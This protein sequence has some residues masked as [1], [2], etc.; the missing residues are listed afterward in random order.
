MGPRLCLEQ[1]WRREIPRTSGLV[2]DT[3][4]TSNYP[5][6]TLYV[7]SKHLLSS[8]AQML[9]SNLPPHSCLVMP[10]RVPSFFPISRVQGNV[11][12]WDTLGM[13]EI[14]NEGIEK[15]ARAVP[16]EP[17]GKARVFGKDKQ[18]DRTLSLLICTS[19][20]HR[21]VFS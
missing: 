19:R 11:Q 21:L 20:D 14:E 16:C 12:R 4:K 6:S 10:I 5:Y 9:A 2:T 15:G 13:R 7:P 1:Q 8:L 3:P 17:Q 18:G